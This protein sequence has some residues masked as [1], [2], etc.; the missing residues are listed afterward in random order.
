MDTRGVSLANLFCRDDKSLRV[1]RGVPSSMR[2]G[3]QLT[4]GMT[5]ALPHELL[6]LRTATPLDDGDMALHRASVEGPVT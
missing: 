1:G 2:M 5:R 6:Q 3:W 4:G